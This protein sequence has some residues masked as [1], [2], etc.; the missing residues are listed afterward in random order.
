M[1]SY[2]PLF[3]FDCYYI[4][5]LFFGVC[6]S[7]SLPLCVLFLGRCLCFHEGLQLISGLIVHGDIP[8]ALPQFL[9][10]LGRIMVANFLQSAPPPTYLVSSLFYARPLYAFSIVGLTSSAP[11]EQED[12]VKGMVA[13]RLACQVNQF[14]FPMLVFSI[15]NSSVL[16]FMEANYIH[17]FSSQVELPEGCGAW[18]LSCSERNTGSVVLFAVVFLTLGLRLMGLIYFVFASL[19][20]LS[21]FDSLVVKYRR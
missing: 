19:K 5:F 11:H 3:A 12:N 17:W 2:S 18:I 8:L 1:P 10:K 13:V 6:L 7:G 9:C 4:F 14:H 15:P 16:C 21:V 20:P